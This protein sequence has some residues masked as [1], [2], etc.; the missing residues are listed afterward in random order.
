[1]T[2]H[3]QSQKSLIWYDKSLFWFPADWWRCTSFYVHFQSEELG[4]VSL[5]APNGDS[6]KSVTLN[7]TMSP[8]ASDTVSCLTGYNAS[9][10]LSWTSAGTR[11]K[12]TWN[13]SVWL[14]LSLWSWQKMYDF[15]LSS[16]L[17]AFSS[18]KDA[19]GQ[20]GL[21]ELSADGYRQ[22]LEELLYIS[23]VSHYHVVPFMSYM[24]LGHWG[25][26]SK[27]KQL[28]SLSGC[29]FATFAWHKANHCV[30]LCINFLGVK[31]YHISLNPTNNGNTLELAVAK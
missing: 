24:G 30:D 7:V 12:H 31:S 18:R 8:H 20:E 6:L 10:F 13:M 15:Y 3:Q 19:R 23:K 21:P 5:G 4:V 25:L 11:N 27:V 9:V 28:F 2:T 17:Y 14:G 16:L 1:M 26:K 29:L 22:H